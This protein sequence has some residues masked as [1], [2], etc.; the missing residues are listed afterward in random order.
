MNRL[1]QKYENEIKNSMVEKFGYKSVMEIP[2]I[3]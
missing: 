2:N 1:R 3:D